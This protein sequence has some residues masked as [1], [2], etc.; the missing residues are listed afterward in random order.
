MAK[1]YGFE[2]LALTLLYFHLKV[3]NN[4]NRFKINHE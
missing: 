3:K 1:S 4:P 2:L